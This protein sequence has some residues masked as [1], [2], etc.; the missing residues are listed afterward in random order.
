VDAAERMLLDPMG[1]AEI[2]ERGA[3]LARTRFRLDRWIERVTAAYEE[4]LV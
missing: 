4:L 2:G 3:L 1:R